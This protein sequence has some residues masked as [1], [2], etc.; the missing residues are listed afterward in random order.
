MS[1]LLTREATWKEIVVPKGT[2]SAALSNFLIK[3]LG[4]SETLIAVYNDKPN[5]ILRFDKEA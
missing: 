5:L 1:G 4:A 3:V 2:T